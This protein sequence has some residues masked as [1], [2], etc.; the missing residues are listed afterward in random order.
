M[1]SRLSR[2]RTSVAIVIVI[3]AALPLLFSSPYIV[4]LGTLSLIFA[5]LASSWDLTLGYAKVFNFAHIVFFA[6]G[7][8]TSAILTTHLGLAPIAGVFIGTLFAGIVAAVVFIPVYR[9]RGIYVAL[10]SFAVTQLAFYLII[11]QREWT[12]GTSGLVGVPSLS[13]GPV[14]LRDVGVGYYYAV[15]LLLIG[16]TYFLRRIVRSDFGLGLIAAGTFEDY[17]RSRGVPIGRTRLQAFVLSALPAGAAGG[18][19]AHYLGVVSPEILSFSFA[20]LVVTMVLVGGAGSI[21]G[22]IIAAAVLTIGSEALGEWGAWR[23]IVISVLMAT[24]VIL[25]PSGLWGMLHYRRRSR[26]K[27]TVEAPG[28]DHSVVVND[29]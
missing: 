18:L 24:S 22:P 16:S 8:Y 2:S 5:V 26:R 19:Y 7:A 9:V 25:V 29:G 11:T 6:I 13:I 10:I 21:Y 3:G 12:G 27:G 17:A 1:T 15:G 20:T 23:F 28:A 4:H 14:D